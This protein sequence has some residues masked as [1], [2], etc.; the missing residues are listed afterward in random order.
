[1][2][3]TSTRTWTLS[4]REGFSQV[5]ETGPECENFNKHTLEASVDTTMCML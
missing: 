4:P 5:V 1:M 2:A 3:P